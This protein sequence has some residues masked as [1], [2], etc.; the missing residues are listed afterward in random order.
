MKSSI[1]HQ[2]LGNE[3]SLN[4]STKISVGQNGSITHTEQVPRRGVQN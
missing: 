4:S 1:G 2:S 3:Q